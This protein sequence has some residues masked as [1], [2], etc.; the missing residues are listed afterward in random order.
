MIISNIT[1]SDKKDGYE[2][3]VSFGKYPERVFWCKDKNNILVR[4]KRLQKLHCRLC[5][6]IKDFMNIR[7]W[8]PEQESASAEKM[9]RFLFQ[10]D[11]VK[12][13]KTVGDFLHAA[14]FEDWD[15]FYS[16][17]FT[18]LEWIGSA[19]VEEIENQSGKLYFTKYYKKA[20]H[21]LLKERDLEAVLFLRLL[22]ETGIR[23]QDVYLV[24][25]SCIKGKRVRM[26]VT[27]F[28]SPDYYQCP[29][30]SFPRI[31]KSTLFIAET[32][33]RVQGKWFTKPYDFYVRIIHKV[34]YQQG[35]SIH[36][37]RQYRIVIMREEYWARQK[38]S[39]KSGK[40]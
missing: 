37:L 16:Q 32:L 9:V 25:S 29:D 2:V 40:K 18:H 6:L 4:Q 5:H 21:E 38:Q 27:K 11:K 8:F 13:K 22:M 34:W 24:D 28:A 26:R 20:I 7:A 1:K 15:G 35:F 19:S 17:Y 31:S 3:K 23:A 33:D 14:E 12:V 10:Y 30:G 39:A 36:L